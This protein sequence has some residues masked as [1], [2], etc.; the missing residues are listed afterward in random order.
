MALTHQGDPW[1]NQ[2]TG[3]GAEAMSKI[4]AGVLACAIGWAAGSAVPAKAADSEPVH[5]MKL[6]TATL[7]DSQHQWMRLFVAAV[8]KASNGRIKGE[9]Y[10]ASQLGTTARQIEGVQFG[11]IQGIVVPPEFMVGVDDR[12][13]ILS[14]S[15]LF[16]SVE[17]ANR[18]I[19]DPQFKKKFLSL[20]ADKGLIGISL[21]ISAPTSIL[22]R[23][24]ARHLADFRGMKIRVLASDFQN[25][26]VKRLGA[27]PV[28]MTLSDVMPALQQGAIDGALATVTTFTPLQY[29]DAAKYLTE[30]GHYF[31][32]SVTDV[33]K[34]WFDALPPDLQK[35]IVDEG[36]KA[37]Q[38]VVPWQLDFIAQQR[39]TW[40]AKG[41]ELISLPPD[42][43]AT[44]MKQLSTVGADLTKSKPAQKEMYDELLAA[45][46][47]AK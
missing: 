33:S 21:F 38:S 25:E 36:D 10:T 43:Q 12:F 8:E 3:K 6:S 32:F 31:V 2:A 24:P 1:S 40:V 17:Q 4:L 29:Y 20:G 39:K 14:A 47:R 41:G 13:E 15:G 44:M 26:E 23:K 22:T 28:A 45:V 7:N 9:I 42:E 34:K 35:I 46:Q 19:S 16:T 11:A 30:T 37:A 27:S 18:V 5:L